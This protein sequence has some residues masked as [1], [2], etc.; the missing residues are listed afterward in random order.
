MIQYMYMKIRCAEQ[1][2]QTADS[3]FRLVGPHHCCV[4]LVALQWPIYNLV[5]PA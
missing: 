4:C 1:T 3:C 5:R 2:R